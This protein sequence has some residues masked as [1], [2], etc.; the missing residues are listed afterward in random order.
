MSIKKAVKKGL[1]AQ[2]DRGYGSSIDPHKVCNVR[3]LALS[4][5]IFACP[6]CFPKSLEIGQ[7]AP[8][9]HLILWDHKFRVIGG[10]GHDGDIIHTYGIKPFPMTIKTPDEDILKQEKEQKDYPLLMDPMDGWQFIEICKKARKYDPGTDGLNFNL[11]LFSMCGKMIK[12]WEKGDVFKGL[13]DMVKN[14]VP[15]DPE[16]AR[17]LNE[18]FWEL[19]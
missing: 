9:Y 12:R 13:V 14:Q 5:L 7:I 18:H 2:L 19:I 8:T 11:W 6:Q 10:Q 1:E 15:L 4:D 3:P 16:Y 17:T